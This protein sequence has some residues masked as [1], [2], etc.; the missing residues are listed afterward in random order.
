M[1]AIAYVDLAAQY[2]EERED[3]LPVVDR[4]LASGQYIGGEPVERLE[5]RIAE[6]L[7][8]AHCVALNSGTDALV[9]ALHGLGI[10][11]GDEVITQPN[12]F[13][14]SAA[15]I[16]HLGARPVFA[17]V[18]PDQSIDPDAVERA[19]TPRT[20]AVMPVHLTG[21]SCDMNRVNAVARKHGL[22]VVE[23]AA[24][25]FLSTFDGKFCGTLG[26]VG[27]FSA[28]PLKN[29]NACGDAGFITTDRDDV[30]RYAQLVRSH[31]LVDRNTVAFWGG[32][33][34]L[35]A[36]QAAILDFR[37][38]RAEGL[39]V[40]RERNAALYRSNLNRS[41]V[42]F[43]DPR[44]NCRDTYH[45][46]V[47]CVENRDGLIQH[48]KTLGIGTAIHYP[49]PIHLQ[50]PGQELG[51]KLGDF[52]E[53]EWQSERILSLPVHQNLSEAQVL[54]VCDAVNGFYS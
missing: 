53:T 1:A 50:A 15:A 30:A 8:V 31:G 22:F 48:L 38:G 12:S 37:L 27:C 46:F 34:R 40:R 32:V 14:A 45:T 7:G 21:R 51:H 26:D 23:D 5:R 16:A 29:L 10:G 19:I 54:Q 25:A 39:I 52:P 3:L 18:L 2:A 35:D 20:K 17:D 43:P 6:M 11:P 36:L 24:Q 28:H 4:L 47:I 13:I 41:K 44:P 9:F 33:S 49:I 42:R